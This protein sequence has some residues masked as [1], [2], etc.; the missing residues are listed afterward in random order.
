MVECWTGC[1]DLEDALPMS[2]GRE[3]PGNEVIS[4]A[5]PLPFHLGCSC[6]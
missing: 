2:S 6:C 5:S 4:R 3:A 1:L